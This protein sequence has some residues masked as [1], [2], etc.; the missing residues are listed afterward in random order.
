MG[1]LRT[2]FFSK[3]CFIPPLPKL[4][5]THIIIYLDKFVIIFFNIFF[6]CEHPSIFS[7]PAPVITSQV[8]A[9][10]GRPMFDLDTCVGS[11][12]VDF[13]HLHASSIQ[14]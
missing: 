3:Q 9:M 8:H 4:K 2:C 14:V 13:T 10:P 6:W 11:I 5:H 12:G 1:Y 7:A